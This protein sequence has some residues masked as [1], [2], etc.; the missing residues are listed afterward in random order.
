MSTIIDNWI[1]L[2]SLINNLN[3]A[4]GQPDA[5]PFILSPPVIEKLSFINDL[6]HQAPALDKL[7]ELEAAE[8]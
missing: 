8:A 7:A 1:P 4:V 3:R 5:Y 6:V 2:S